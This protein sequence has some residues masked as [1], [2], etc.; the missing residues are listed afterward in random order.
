MPSRL[1]T[2]R[3]GPTNKPNNGL[4][5]HLIELWLTSDKEDSEKENGKMGQKRQERKNEGK[6]KEKE[7]EEEDR[8]I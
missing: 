7:K 6:K 8:M 3:N 2:P 1:C 4:S 5:H